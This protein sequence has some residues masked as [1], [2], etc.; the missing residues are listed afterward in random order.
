MIMM[1]I[2]SWMILQ[3]EYYSKKEIEVDF[4]WEIYDKMMLISII[5]WAVILPLACC[6]SVKTISW[7]WEIRTTKRKNVTIIAIEVI[8]LKYT[9]FRADD[10]LILTSS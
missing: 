2:P 7:E 10:K 5:I 8:N 9:I 1:M 3:Y 6:M 4:I